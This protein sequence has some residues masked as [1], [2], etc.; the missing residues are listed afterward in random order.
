MRYRFIHQ[1]RWRFPVGRMC[2]LLAVS[3]SG[4]SGW[5]RRPESERDRQNRRLLVAIRTVHQT[6]RGVYGSPRVHAELRARGHH[7]G[8]HRVARLMRQEGLRAR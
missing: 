7:C 3:R 1:Y 5:R 4:D 8:R 2:A 6:T